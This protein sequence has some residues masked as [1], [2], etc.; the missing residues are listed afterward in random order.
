MQGKREPA[1]V[2][3]WRFVQI[4]IDCW[5]WSGSKD[6]KG[7]GRIMINKKPTLVHRFSY[8]FYRGQ[9]PVGQGVCHHCDNPA[10][11]RP[12][13]LFLGTQAENMRDA[14]KKLRIRS[15]RTGAYQPKTHCNVGHELTNDNLYTNPN[16]SR[17]CRTCS[18]IYQQKRR[19]SAAQERHHENFC[20][21]P[22]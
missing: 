14:A 10:C 20:G 19:A 8:E 3:F 9:I 22:E 16:G 17:I 4:G 15:K 13:H 21:V 2:R 6:Q 11:V 12:S 7:Y 18:N 5:E 1:N